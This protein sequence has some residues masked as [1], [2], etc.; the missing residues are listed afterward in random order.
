[1]TQ[2]TD[3]HCESPVSPEPAVAA[4]EGV[5]ASMEELAMVI[6]VVAVGASTL[7]ETEV[8]HDAFKRSVSK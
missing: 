7:D 3:V 1:M 8:P 6:D 4:A 5:D 2:Q